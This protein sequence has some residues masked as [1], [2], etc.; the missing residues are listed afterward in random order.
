MLVV[1]NHVKSAQMIAQDLRSEID[2]SGVCLFHGRFNMRD[3]TEKERNLSSGNLPQVLVATQVVEVSLDISYQTGYFEAAPIDALA[4]RMGRVN[5]K[6]T[7]PPC[8]VTIAATPLNKH[9][10]YDSARTR[11]TLEL[12]SRLRGPISEHDLVTTCDQVYANGY[13][14]EDLDTFRDH[15]GHRYLTQ[16]E[17][18]IVAGD[19]ENWIDKVIE[20]VDNRI[21]VLPACLLSEFNQ[22]REQRRWLEAD[23]LMVSI[24][25]RST[26]LQ[27]YIRD[28]GDP[29]VINLPYTSNGLEMP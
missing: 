12:V 6:A 15:L 24:P 28:D 7:L 29:W 27:K 5:R 20:N 1:C 14:G 8:P 4:Q 21:E 25:S 13:E 19:H 11:L 17:S 9:P 16:F 18:M 10:I 23:A 22:L 3:R 2:P 26:R